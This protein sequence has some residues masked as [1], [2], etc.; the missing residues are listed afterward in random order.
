MRRRSTGRG[1]E[2]EVRVERGEAGGVPSE[3]GSKAVDPELP[4]RRRSRSNKG[5]LPMAGYS[6]IETLD[7]SLKSAFYRHAEI[8]PPLD[9]NELALIKAI[10]EHAQATYRLHH[11]DSMQGWSDAHADLAI[12]IGFDAV[13]AI[14]S[15]D[16]PGAS[17]LRTKHSGLWDV[18]LRFD[19]AV[20]AALLNKAQEVGE[21][22]STIIARLKTDGDLPNGGITT[23]MVAAYVPAFLIN[24]P[25]VE[26]VMNNAAF[27]AAVQRDADE[28]QSG[29]KRKAARRD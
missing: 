7:E 26:N 4:A 2:E 25:A 13:Q 1:P 5:E 21:S 27:D 10:G 15:P 6:E 23:T 18:T 9:A 17:S 3:T 20:S 11:G 22:P 8:V 29:I 28:L 19:A 24:F 16:L 12:Q 14:R